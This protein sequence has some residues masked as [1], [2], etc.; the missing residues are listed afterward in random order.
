[1]WL[2]LAAAAAIAVVGLGVWLSRGPSQTTDPTVFRGSGP[3]NLVIRVERRPDGGA[4]VSWDA[5]PGAASYVARLLR[6]DGVELWKTEATEP[7][8]RIPPGELQA[9]GS[10]AELL[11]EIEALDSRRRVVSSSP[12]TAL[13]RP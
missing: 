8:V 9:G 2:P 11:V 6:P 7:N 4:E 3:Q 1:M 13:P 5:T 10:G 12:P